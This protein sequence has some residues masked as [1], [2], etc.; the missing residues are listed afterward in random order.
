VLN[1]KNPCKKNFF[2]V[3]WIY[4]NHHPILRSDVTSEWIMPRD[5]TQNRTGRL[6]EAD[7][8]DVMSRLVL[9][10][11]TRQ[12]RGYSTACLVTSLLRPHAF[13][14][15]TRSSSTD[16]SVPHCFANSTNNAETGSDIFFSWQS[17]F[18]IEPLK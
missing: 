15:A 10:S 6:E 2:T 16:T 8:H 13:T 11:H 5:E 12:R 9:A 3:T 14:L 18:R 4:F 1:R 17:S 7:K